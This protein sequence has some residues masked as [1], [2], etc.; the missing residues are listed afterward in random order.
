VLSKHGEGY[1]SAVSKKL[2]PHSR[3]KPFVQMHG[4][5]ISLR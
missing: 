2:I 1:I 3:E 5:R 4:L